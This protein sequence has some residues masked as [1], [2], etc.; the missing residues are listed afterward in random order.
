MPDWAGM[1]NKCMDEHGRVV[2]F[3]P[4]LLQILLQASKGSNTEEAILC[5]GAMNNL[6]ETLCHNIVWFPNEIS[7]SHQNNLRPIVT[8]LYDFCLVY[9]LDCDDLDSGM[10]LEAMA[11]II[12]QRERFTAQFTGPVSELVILNR[13]GQFAQLYLTM[14]THSQLELL[15][16]HL[17]QVSWSAGQAVNDVIQVLKF[18]GSPDCKLPNAVKA[19]SN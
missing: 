17:H 3:L 1:L 16:S 2:E 18:L 9:C 12:T 13:V 10:K 19:I 8:G 4:V 11:K 15:L 14:K 6:S 7:T 5:I